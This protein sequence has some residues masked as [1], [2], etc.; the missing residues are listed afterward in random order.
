MTFLFNFGKTVAGGHFCHYFALFVKGIASVAFGALHYLYTRGFGVEDFEDLAESPF[1]YL[2]YEFVAL[3]DVI[4][5]GGGAVA[6]IMLWFF[7]LPSQK[8]KL[9]RNENLKIVK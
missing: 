9:Y 8:T 6:V 5:L 1:A 3:G 4:G 2:F 7:H